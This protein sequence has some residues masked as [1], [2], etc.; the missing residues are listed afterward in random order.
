[1]RAQFIAD[2][3]LRPAAPGPRRVKLTSLPV[4]ELAGGLTV[5]NLVDAEHHKHHETGGAERLNG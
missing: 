3:R 2:G 5:K 1:M 4:V